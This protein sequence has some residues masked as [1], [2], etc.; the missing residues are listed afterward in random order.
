VTELPANTPRPA[1]GTLIGVL[2]CL[3]DKVLVD[4]KSGLSEFVAILK[5]KAIEEVGLMRTKE[6]E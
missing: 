1:Q 4:L 5:I 6:G 3:P 2:L